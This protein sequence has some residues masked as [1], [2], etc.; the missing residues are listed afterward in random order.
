MF[1]YRSYRT[2]RGIVAAVFLF[3]AIGAMAWARSQ[4]PVERTPTEGE[5][6]EVLKAD[7]GSGAQRLVRLRLEDGREARVLVPGF[8]ARVGLDVPL[9]VETYR[10][11]ERNA[12]FFD[13]EGWIDRTGAR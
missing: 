6:L 9:V 12:V 3:G 5:V 13:Q 8:A 4:G 1:R 10:K 2:A 11:K 7:V